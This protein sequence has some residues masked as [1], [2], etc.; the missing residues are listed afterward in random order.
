[1]KKILIAHDVHESLEQHQTFL[2]RTDFK[3]FT[4][5][6]N[7]EAFKIH[8]A[9]LVDLIITRLHMPGMD[10]E[11]FCSLIRDDNQL[12]AASL[13]LICANTPDA[14]EQAGRCRANAVLIEPLHPVVLMVKAQQLL[15]IAGRETLRVLLSATVDSLSEDE[16]FFCRT[17]N[18]S[19]TGMLIE[20]NKQLAKGARLA[21]SFYLPNAKKIQVSCKIIR[22]ALAAPGDEDNR[23][24]LM[25]VDITHE[26]KHLLADYIVKSSMKE[27]I[28]GP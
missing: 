4:A 13:I 23:Y 24:G 14:I 5:K 6:T 12:R 3:V 11:H 28:A 26:A 1:M 15:E 7:D 19:A 22:A 18:V 25:F 10:G 2:D 20:T 21:C 17:V 27:R 16:P 8:Q 9:E